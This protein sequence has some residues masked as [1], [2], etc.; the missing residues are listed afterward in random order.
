MRR[1]Q[2]VK[3]AS[4]A[5]AGPST[6]VNEPELEP[7]TQ[8]EEPLVKPAHV[9][10]FSLPWKSLSTAIEDN[11]GMSMLDEGGG[12]MLLEE[13]DG[14]DVQ[15]EEDGWGGKKAILKMV[16]PGGGKKGRS[17]KG[18][19]LETSTTSRKKEGKDK[20]RKRNVEENDV[21]VKLESE[22]ETMA[23]GETIDIPEQETN[24]NE[25]D[26]MEVEPASAFSAFPEETG[27]Q[28]GSDEED[29]IASESGSES[30]EEE[31]L[32]E[33]VVDAPFDGMFFLPLLSIL[34][35]QN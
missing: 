26:A 16:E 5:E 11:P 33:L 19:V 17:G 6:G 4:N 30:E 1:N 10:S 35:T 18:K 25:S 34:T 32:G 23:Q 27:S 20:K 2:K 9:P 22:D 28:L 3:A 31:E 13:V 21:E 24:E 29:L 12:M 7:A 8:V 14:V 15:W